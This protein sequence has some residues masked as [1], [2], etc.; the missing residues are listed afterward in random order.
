MSPTNQPFAYDPFSPE[1]MR[2]PQRFYPT[3]REEHPAYFLPQY[4]TYVFSRYA[5]VWEGFLDAE[6]FS[7]A[8]GQLFAREQLLTHRRGDP[9]K[10]KLDPVDMFNFV[11]PPVLTRF[12]RTMNPPFAKPNVAR[13]AD[14]ITAMVRAR[15]AE[16]APRG[17]FDLNGDFA[18]F[19]SVAATSMILGLPLG[20][21]DRMVSLAN[22]LT[23]RD[24]DKPGRTADGAA[25]REEL[26]ALLSD[27]AAMRRAGRGLE[28]TFID[29]LIAAEDIVGHPLSDMEIAAQLVAIL[30]GGVETVPKIIAGGTHELARRPDQLAAV[31]ADPAANAAP[32]FEEMLR[33]NAP[34]QWF[35]RTVKKRRELGG[36]TLEPGQR[37]ILLIAAANRDPR[38]FEDPD[39]FVWN[40][41]HRRMLSFGVGP[42]FCI[43]VH[44]ARLEGQIMLRELV[45]AIPRF[46][47]EP[48]N[49]AWA[50][51]EFQVGWT[52]LPL[53]VETGA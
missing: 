49:G 20:E 11:D 52:R 5:D 44:L 26:Y 48:E 16:L 21:T 9:P 35:G 53:R 3:L 8:E 22:R 6:H 33:Y 30:V 17:R 51:S 24:P 12:R 19:I 1:A 36:V 25:A 15:L 23:A 18:S 38:E 46:A 14:Q 27:V 47:V 43:G 40:R 13:L 37:V 2:D 32:A 45:S 50:V 34:A 29:A 42:H 31:R 39:A 7:E 10:P 28:S 4:D 41:R